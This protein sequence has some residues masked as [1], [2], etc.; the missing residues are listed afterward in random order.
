M[1][2]PKTR[3][4]TAS[5]AKF[6]AGVTPEQR[7]LD[8]RTVVK[9]MRLATG[10]RPRLWGPNIVGFGTHL[11]K[12]AS[13]RELEWPLV[14]FSPRKTSLVLYLATGFPRRAA[15]VAKLGKVKT[16]GGCIYV[17]KLADVDTDVL[18]ELIRASVAHKRAKH[19]DK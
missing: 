19:A 4:T 11:M 12:Y 2:E 5:V 17:G 14:G 8:A 1:A 10:E 13:G 3:P 18:G 9:I 7:R 6:I 15:L 16:G